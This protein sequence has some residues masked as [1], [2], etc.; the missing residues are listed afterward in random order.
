[1]CLRAKSSLSKSSGPEKAA[2]L[3]YIKGIKL[4]KSTTRVRGRVPT[5]R[6]FC[7]NQAN[8][9][10][11]VRECLH[12]AR[13]RRRRCAR[14]RRNQK[15]QVIQEFKCKNQNAKPKRFKKVAKKSRLVHQNQDATKS[16]RDSETAR[17]SDASDTRRDPQKST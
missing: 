2:L 12:S 5:R 11:Q 17:L 4:F 9:N 16:R 14:A 15:N 6:G 7:G 10:N 8:S 3:K 13:C 1:M